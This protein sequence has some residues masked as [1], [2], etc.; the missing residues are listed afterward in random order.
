MFTLR[1]RLGCLLY[2]LPRLA[3]RLYGPP[4][5]AGAPAWVAMRNRNEGLIR[6][7]LRPGAAC[8]GE[9][10]R[11]LHVCSVFPAAGRRLLRRALRD[12]PLALREAPDH[13]ADGVCANGGAVPAVRPEVS[14]LIGHRGAERIPLL[15]AVLRSIAGQTTV[16]FECLVVEQDLEPR[17]A[18]VLPPWVRL[19]RAPPPDARTPYLRSWALNVAARAARGDALVFHDGDLLLPAGF[20]EAVRLRLDGADVVQPKRF[21]FYLDEP[22]TRR[23]CD[24]SGDLSAARCVEVVENLEAGASVALKREAFF[25][26]GGWDEEFRGWG[27]EDNEFWDRCRTLRVDPYGFLPMIHLWHSPQPDRGA[28]G[29]PGLTRMVQRRMLSPEVRIAQ[30]SRRAFG[31]TDGPTERGAAG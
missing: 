9:F 27:G 8:T 7:P 21:T 26:I 17:L 24:G 29:N 31:R 14:F 10:S 3:W 22:A 16:P 18:G 5:S 19:L 12:W 23:M 2:D 28:S 1:Q 6:D 13:V 30:L 15:R 25:A 20:A 4:G 11:P